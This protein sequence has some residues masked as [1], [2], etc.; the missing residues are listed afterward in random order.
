MVTPL[1]KIMIDWNNFKQITNYS[2]KLL[3]VSLANH[4]VLC[5][6]KTA[7]LPLCVIGNL[8]ELLSTSWIVSF[9]SQY[10]CF[11][12]PTQIYRYLR[13]RNMISPIFLHRSLT[14]MKKRTS[15]PRSEKSRQEFKVDS[16]LKRKEN[17]IKDSDPQKM[18]RFMNLTFLGYYDRKCKHHL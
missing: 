18:D 6:K 7:F 9:T 1:Q 12:E 4:A 17:E 5:C 13:T 10:V 15:R 14:F 8:F 3:K 16:L 11:S 2:F